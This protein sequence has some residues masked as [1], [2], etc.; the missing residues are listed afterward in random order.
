MNIIKKILLKIKT[1]KN[2]DIDQNK[3]KIIENNIHVFK[4]KEQNIDA[5]Y[6][7]K[8][9][10]F[11]KNIINNQNNQEHIKWSK[12]NASYIKNQSDS[13]F[14]F[15]FLDENDINLIEYK[16]YEVLKNI[17]FEYEDIKN[18]YLFNDC[19]IFLITMGCSILFIPLCFFFKHH[20]G[21]EFI[22]TAIAMLNMLFAMALSCYMDT[23]TI[24]KR[25]EIDVE[26]LIEQINTLQFNQ[27][28]LIE[29]QNNEIN[30][31]SN[32]SSEVL[33]HHI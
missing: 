4:Q 10:E 8:R 32:Y 33:F 25:N 12:K 29:N 18:K 17:M 23:F 28:N 7:T 20:T 26:T 13:D 22:I 6:H 19:K 16:E 9:K 3:I 31:L 2:I 14:I 24:R 30:I 27:N 11:L 15:E 1:I 5:E 21:I